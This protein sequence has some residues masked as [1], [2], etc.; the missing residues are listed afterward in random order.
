MEWD[1]GVGGIGLL[2]AMALGFAV[3]AQLI[4]WVVTPH[5]FWA[6]AF[7]AYFVSGLFV[8]EI[9]FGWATEKDL[10]SNIDGLSFDEVLLL[11]PLC[12]IG[13]LFLIWMAKRGAHA[14][15]ACMIRLVE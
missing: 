12:A 6:V 4:F 9:W 8:S 1:L 14:L 2:L 13:V 7:T 15:R 5:W 11:A 3:L 10:Q